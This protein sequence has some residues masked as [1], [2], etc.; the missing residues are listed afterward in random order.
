MKTYL[1]IACK[2]PL[3]NILCFI[4]LLFFSCIDLKAQQTITSSQAGTITNAPQGDLY[5]TSDTD[6]LYMGISNGT[7]RLIGGEISSGGGSGWNLTGNTITGSNFLGTVN[8]QPLTIKV[9][10]ATMGYLHP[11]GG[12]AIGLGAS[13]NNTKALALGQNA[14]AGGNESTALGYGAASSGYQS[15]AIGHGAQASNNS[16]LALG[17]DA[18]ASGQNATAIGYQT[19]SSGQNAMALGNGA[20]AVNPNT[21][22]LGNTTADTQYAGTKIGLGTNSPSVRLDV[23]G[24]V[25]IVDGTQG[26]GKVLTS[27]ANGKAHWEAPTVSI[28]TI[29]EIYRANNASNQDLSTNFT[30]IVFGSTQVSQGTVSIL[31]DGTGI[32]VTAAGLYRVTYRVSTISL[33]NREGGEFKLLNNGSDVDGSYA[34]TY[35]RDANNV[36]KDTATATKILQLN[37]Y[38]TLTVQGRVYAYSSFTHNLDVVSGGANLIVEKL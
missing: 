18:N 14:A 1:R 28:T 23:A 5:I 30:T 25:K 11:Q 27:D 16:G 31:G 32:Q 17:Y 29:A 26:T 33:N 24:S 7:L 37:A 15:T 6:Q 21:I 8:Y 9:N 3:V 10:N 4:G 22:I 35:S 19:S 20:T 13:A 12:L 38:N 34:Y 36:D 2:R